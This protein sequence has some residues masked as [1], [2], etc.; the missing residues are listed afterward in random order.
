M[1]VADGAVKVDKVWIAGDIGSQII[2]PINAEHQSQG[3]AI[4]GLA[5][6]LVL[7][8]IVQEQG[9][10]IAENFGEFPLLRM[11][12]KPAEIALEW[13]KSD[14]PP[15]GL[16]EPALPPVIP[17]V[18]NAIYRATGKRLRSLPLSLG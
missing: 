12:G 6:A 2:N 17:A 3:A 1:T 15:T 8:P 14:F 9:R 13:V 5:Q 11:D 4:E 7:Q 10:V 18:A 16:G